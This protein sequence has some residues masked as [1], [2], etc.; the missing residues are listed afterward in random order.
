ML[1]AKIE[2]V[3]DDRKERGGV[4]FNDADLI[5][6]PFRVTVGNKT[7]NDGLVEIKIRATGE[8]IDLPIEEAAAFLKE[9]IAAAK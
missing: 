2:V 5:G 4:K 8:V 6:Y 1:K 7:K 9:K 3:L